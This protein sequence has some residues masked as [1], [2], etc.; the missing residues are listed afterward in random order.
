MLGRLRPVVSPFMVRVARRLGFLP[1]YV[2]TVAGF[3]ASL[4]YLV[5][6][7]LGWP[8]VGLL[9][10]AAGGFMDAVDGAVARLRGEAS[11][12]GAL[13]DSTLDRLSDAAYIYGLGVAGMPW[14]L[15][16][17]FM[18]LSLLISYVRAR[19][20]SLAGPGA[21][22]EGVG[23]VERPE[24]L[25]L[26]FLSLLAWVVWRPLG[27]A[28]LAAAVA[29]SLVGFAWRFAAAYRRLGSGGARSRV[30]G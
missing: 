30:H 22:L 19:F 18:V 26:V 3:A 13:L 10:V 29:A 23:L 1:A 11:S 5:V 24:R 27:L 15:V 14:G 12:R 25:I 21:C 2:F 6:V 4:A 20:E 28:V 17:L 8:V 16:Y 7:W 9:L